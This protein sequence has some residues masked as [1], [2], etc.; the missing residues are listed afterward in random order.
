MKWNRK[1]L[2]LCSSNI[3]YSKNNYS[4]FTTGLRKLDFDGVCREWSFLIWIIS[5]QLY[6]FIMFEG[7]NHGMLNQ[8]SCT[9]YSH[10]NFPHFLPTN[11]SPPHKHYILTSGHITLDARLFLSCLCRTYSFL[12]SPHWSAECT[13]PNSLWLPLYLSGKF[14]L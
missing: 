10:H 1:L 5:I 6:G 4:K 11:S 9:L 8:V 7:F 2:E 3:L 14:S 13:Y 12:T